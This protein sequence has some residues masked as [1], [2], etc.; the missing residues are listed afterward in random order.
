MLA[1]EFALD[2]A[3]QADGRITL[4]HVI[5]WLAEERPLTPMAFNVA[6]YRS[7][8]AADAENRLRELVAEEPRT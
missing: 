5:E 7:A 2:L 4:L 6:E 8:L 1:L 3:R